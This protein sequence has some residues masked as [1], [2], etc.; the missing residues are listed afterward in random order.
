MDFDNDNLQISHQQRNMN[1]PGQIRLT[2]P[3]RL[4]PPLFIP[5]LGGIHIEFE[6]R[7]IQVEAQSL[8][9]VAIHMHEGLQI[10]GHQDPTNRSGE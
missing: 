6:G 1:S 8:E 9:F 4:S 2:Q 3:S 10:G 5:V 7:I